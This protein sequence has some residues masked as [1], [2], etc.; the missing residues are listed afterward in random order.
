MGRFRAQEEYEESDGVPLVERPALVVGVEAAGLPTDPA[1]YEGRLPVEFDLYGRAVGSVEDAFTAAIGLNRGEINWRN[2][3]RPKVP[4]QG[5]YGECTHAEVTLLFNTRT[6]DLD[7]PADGRQMMEPQVRWLAG[8]TGLTVLGPGQLRNVDGVLSRSG[9]GGA[10]SG[11]SRAEKPHGAVT[12]ATRSGR[13]RIQPL[14][15]GRT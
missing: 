11:S 15:R 2:L 9:V 3:C 6:R 1:S 10:P 14:E 8:Q 12:G 5:L 13:W 7:E 4:S